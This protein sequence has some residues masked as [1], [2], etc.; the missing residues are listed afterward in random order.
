[1]TECW[2]A[3]VGRNARST[4]NMVN[5]EAVEISPG[6]GGRIVGLA[7]THSVTLG[8]RLLISKMSEASKM[9]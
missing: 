3:E 4:S 9:S 7:L 2:G 6:W 8:L 5:Q 1:M